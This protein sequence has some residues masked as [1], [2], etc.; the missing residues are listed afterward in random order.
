MKKLLMIMMAI[1]FALPALSE[2]LSLPYEVYTEGREI[3]EGP[4]VV[5]FWTD[6][7]ST[8]ARQERVVNELRK[9]GKYD[10][11][12]FWEVD[13]DEH[14]ESEIASWYGVHRRSTLVSVFEGTRVDILNSETRSARIEEFLDA[15]VSVSEK[16]V[17]LEDAAL[18]FAWPELRLNSEGC[19]LG[20]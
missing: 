5:V 15:L 19:T 2:E 8:C 20:C 17:L 3:G 13:W 16:E 7:C 18:P 6:W 10:G 1:F 11:I 9:S 12:T 4:V 14:D